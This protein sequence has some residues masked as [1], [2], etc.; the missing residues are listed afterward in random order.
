V[1]ESYYVTISGV[2]GGV[3]TWIA[4]EGG[5]ALLGYWFFGDF[6]GTQEIKVIPVD[7]ESPYEPVT[8]TIHTEPC[9]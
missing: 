5:Y 9:P 3:A 8:L 2:G 1:P 6:T 7:E 4:D